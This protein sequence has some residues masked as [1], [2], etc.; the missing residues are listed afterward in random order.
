M[1]DDRGSLVTFGR[2]WQSRHDRCRI[3]ISLD[4]IWSAWPFWLKLENSIEK[5]MFSM[6]IVALM[7][8]L[9]ASH[10]WV[11]V[12]D[13]CDGSV[14]LLSWDRTPFRGWML[15]SLGPWSGPY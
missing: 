11:R 14:A 8:R 4:A 5:S 10:A 3:V 9:R 12:L 7:G 2:S 15:T 13:L 6:A 1:G